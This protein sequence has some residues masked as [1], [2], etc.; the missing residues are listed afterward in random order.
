M[1]SVGKR[2]GKPTINHIRVLQWIASHERD[3]TIYAPV[4]ASHKRAMDL[5][6]Y[7]LATLAQGHPSSG[8]QCF[9]ATDAGQTLL[10]ALDSVAHD[11]KHF[12]WMREN[13]KN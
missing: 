11:D 5:V 13:V 4:G 6:K 9:A 7:G 10:V 2:K 8:S 1:S 3:G 12:Y